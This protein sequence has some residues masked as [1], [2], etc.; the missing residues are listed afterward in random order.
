MAAA[1][2][3]RAATDRRLGSEQASARPSWAVRTRSDDHVQAPTRNPKKLVDTGNGRGHQVK[4]SDLAHE[5]RPTPP[6]LCT[7]AVQAIAALRQHG[8]AY[9]AAACTSVSNKPRSAVS[10]PRFNRY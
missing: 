1:G 8:L 10:E 7:L 6:V 5:Y 3:Q 2:V 4:L 9:P